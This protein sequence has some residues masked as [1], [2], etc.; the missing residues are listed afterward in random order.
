MLDPVIPDYPFDW[1]LLDEEQSCFIHE[2]RRESI[3]KEGNFQ[4]DS[5]KALTVASSCRFRGDL[6][7]K[8]LGDGYE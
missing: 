3:H 7:M 2:F 8:S 5:L 6:T 4:L 1:V